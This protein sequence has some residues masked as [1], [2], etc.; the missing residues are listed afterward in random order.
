M[1]PWEQEQS[2]GSSCSIVM[3]DEEW[4][5]GGGLWTNNLSWGCDQIPDKEKLQGGF[6]LAPNWRVQSTVAG[7]TWRWELLSEGVWGCLLN[8]RAGNR[9]GTG[10][11]SGLWNSRLTP[12][13][14]AKGPISSQNSGISLGPSVQLCEPIKAIFHPNCNRLHQLDQWIA[15]PVLASLV[16]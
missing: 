16:S 5:F 3:L 14:V 8:L 4:L 1:D 12:I 13:H 7:R 6:I 10:I 15:W 11:V 2:H 9:Y